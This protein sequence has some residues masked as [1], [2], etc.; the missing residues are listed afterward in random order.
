[1]KIGLYIEHGV[2][3]GVGGA[4]LMMA[5]LASAWSREHDVDLVNH[6]P[7][8][9][10]ERLASFT[11]DPLDRVNV[12][13]VPREPDP[14]ASGNPFRRYRDAREWHASVS[15]PY[16]LFV[17][18]THWLPCFNHA[19]RGAMLVLF[20]FYVR[21]PD[22]PEMRRLPQWK[23]FRHQAY[24]DFEWRRRMATYA[25]RAAISD[26]ARDWTSRRWQVDCEVVHPPVDIDLPRRPKEPLLLSVGR[27]S[28]MAH[29]KKQAEMMQA[30]RELQTPLNGWS[31]A[32]VGGLNAREENHAY[33]DRVRSLGEGC[34]TIVEANVGR[35]RLRELFGRARIYW[36]ATGLGDDTAARPELAEHFGISTVEAM[37]AGCVPVVINKGGQPEI[38]EHGTSG[39]VW[40]T[41]E[42]LKGYTE[43]LARDE[44]LRARMS[45]AAIRRAGMFARERFVARMSAMCGVAA[46]SAAAASVGSGFSRTVSV[47]ASVTEAQGSA[48]RDLTVV[49]CTYNRAD[50]LRPALDALLAQTGDV[51]Y[52]VIVVDNNSTD[53]TASVVSEAAAR[54]P[55]RLRY[56]FEGRQGLSHARN[57]GI[58]LAHGHIV[59]FTDDDVRVDE[60]WAAQIVRAF[61]AN[62]DVD[63]LGGRVLPHW[64]KPAPRWLTTAHWS[65]LA[66]QDYGPEAFVSSRDRAICLVGANLAFRREVF[67]RVGVFAP[68]LGRIKDGIGSTEDHDMQ[69][70]IWRAGMR[71]RYEPSIVAIADVTPD[72]LSRAYHRRWH[73]G[74]GR[75]CASMRLRELVPADMGPMS[76]PRDLVLLWG[77]PAFVYADLPQFAFL[78]MRAIA[79]REDPFFYANKMRHVWSYLRA[80]WAAQTTK[81]ARAGIQE[82]VTFAKAYRRK[83][84]SVC[85]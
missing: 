3:N 33:F 53:A 55:G 68:E 74:H 17:N 63:Y 20:P 29:T 35:D 45:E 30:F 48:D 18:C 13:S 6:R 42:E 72:R 12:R 22:M 21:P 25:H 5:H 77:V 65:P 64:L 14:P 28:T 24:Y 62:A 27:F 81:G 15:A 49:L 71:G 2:G 54:A 56:A 38:V 58:A 84:L 80:R 67:D 39:F 41:I 59:A 31:Y 61:Q 19:R 75:H 32:S 79:R 1:M 40:N 73:R 76:E 60:G 34:S 43:L 7:P 10:R 26:F 70:R 69:L 11:D 78:W 66:L 37:A 82:L 16:D 9:T 50:R 4:E 83:R 46:A 57:C 52:E 51:D 44:A 36:H 8:L 85:R 23:R 47:G